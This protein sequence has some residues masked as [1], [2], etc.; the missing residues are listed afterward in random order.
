MGGNIGHIKF[1]QAGIYLV[2]RRKRASAG[3]LTGILWTRRVSLL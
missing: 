1:D 3:I 2:T